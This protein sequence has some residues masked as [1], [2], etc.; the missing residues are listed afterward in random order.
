M[1]P[2]SKSPM[3]PQDFIGVDGVEGNIPPRNPAANVGVDLETDICPCGGKHKCDDY[4]CCIHHKKQQLKQRENMDKA[5][6]LLKKWCTKHR[7]S[8]YGEACGT[9]IQLEILKQLT[10]LT[11]EKTRPW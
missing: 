11:M 1:K 3:V 6:K 4:R 7:N 8:Y 5:K 9:C 10:K 2:V